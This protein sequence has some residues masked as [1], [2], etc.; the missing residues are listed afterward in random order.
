MGFDAPDFLGPELVAIVSLLDTTL[1]K[2]KPEGAAGVVEGVP[3]NP[4]K[5]PVAPEGTDAALV[6]QIPTAISIL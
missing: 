6:L 2:E 4:P 1:P 3:P 5:P